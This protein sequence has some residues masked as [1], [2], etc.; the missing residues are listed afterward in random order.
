MKNI[1]KFDMFN[2]KKWIQEIGM[3]KGALKKSLG[4]EEGEKLTKTE[5]NAEISKLKKKDKDS[6]KKGVQGLSKKDLTKYK[7][8][9]LA[10]TLS[11]LKEHQTTNNY[12][13]F[14][15]LETMKRYIDA[16]MELS[17]EEVDS[18]LSEH[19]WASDHISVACENL[20]HVHNFL[21]NHEEPHQMEHGIEMEEESSEECPGCDCNPC[22]C[23]P[24]EE[25]NEEEEE[26]GIKGFEDFK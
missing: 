12:M 24:E 7:R 2:E 9:N 21:L 19:D 8:L 1:K 20:E 3:K 4:K 16:I 26:S 14:A 23:N 5:I 11:N 15:N 13:F 6:E 10:K 17:Q 25:E 18:I 22:K